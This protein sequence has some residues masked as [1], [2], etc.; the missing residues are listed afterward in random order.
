MEEITEKKCSLCKQILP[1]SEFYKDRTSKDGFQHACKSCRKTK[2]EQSPKRKAYTKDY[3]KRNSGKIRVKHAIF[4]ADHREELLEKH[5]EYHATHKEQEA[6]YRA[7]NRDKHN[8]SDKERK[9]QL[10]LYVISLYGGHCDLC[11]PANPDA[12]NPEFLTLDH[13]NGDGAEHRRAV[14]R[15]AGYKIYAE[16]LALGVPDFS[17]FRLLCWNHNDETGIT[18]KKKPFNLLSKS[19]QKARRLRDE[20]IAAYG[21]KCSCCGDDNRLHLQL[22][23]V[24]GGGNKHLRAEGSTAHFRDAKRRGY[25]KDYEV[26]C[27]NC[28]NSTHFGGGLCVHERAKTGG[29]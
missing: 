1:T 15:S 8:R 23:H 19:E 22:H 18:S 25:P 29:E 14:G 6:E 20:V 12:W 13:V 21:G 16:V 11:G 9:Q 10:K 24:E 3:N 4:R 26:R 28:N 27:A 5:R 7:K 2:Y 17:R